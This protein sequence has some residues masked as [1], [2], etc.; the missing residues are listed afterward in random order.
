[1]SIISHGTDLTLASTL[2]PILAATGGTVDAALKRLSATG[3][4]AVQLDATRRGIR[5]RE[6][7]ARARR[8]LTALLTRRSM[9]VAGLDLFIPRRHYSDPVQVDRAI[10]ATTAAIRLAAD[11]GRVPVSLQLPVDPV[12]EDVE[13][14]LIEAADG[15]GVR[16]A[17]HA[18]DRLS[19]LLAWVAKV[20]QKCL[21]VGID[22]AALLAAGHDPMQAVSQAGDRLHVARLTDTT[23]RDAGATRC[24]VGEGDLDVIPYRVALDLATRR[25]GPVVADPRGLTAP[26]AAVETAVRV[27]DDAAF[28]L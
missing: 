3:C 20:D 2:T 6:L 9:R 16:L 21:G 19:D 24:V 26:L 18:E 22:P 7:T 13:H 14:A 8:D 25:Q 27:W 15:C 10:T 28:T 23:A 11:L 4:Q 12:P 1:M 17:V 5:P